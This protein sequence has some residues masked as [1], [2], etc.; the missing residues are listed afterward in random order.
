MSDR[1]STT[2]KMLRHAAELGTAAGLRYV[3]AG[4]LP[5]KVGSLEN[6]HCPQCREVVV[7]R[8]GYLIR[9]YN[10]TPDGACPS[11]GTHISGKWSNEFTEQRT[12]F[13]IRMYPDQGLSPR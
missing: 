2:P 11:C 10:L 6:T 1:P 8:Y 4:N 13:P 5:G 3:Y 12:A 9:G 7:E